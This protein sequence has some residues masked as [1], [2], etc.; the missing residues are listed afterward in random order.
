MHLDLGHHRKNHNL[1]L[2]ILRLHPSVQGKVLLHLS[3]WKVGLAIDLAVHNHEVAPLPLEIVAQGNTPEDIDL[4][5]VSVRRG[6]YVPDKCFLVTSLTP[7][8]GR[9]SS[10]YEYASTTVAFTSSGKE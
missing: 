10:K 2:A 6:Y 7:R 3:S 1:L 9:G 5:E 4:L 8:V